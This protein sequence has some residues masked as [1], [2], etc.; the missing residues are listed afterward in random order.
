MGEILSTA[1]CPV[2][3]SI[4]TLGDDRDEDEVKT[5]DLEAALA[6]RL[7]LL[8]RGRNHFILRTSMHDLGQDRDQGYHTVDN[9]VQ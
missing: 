5:S 6:S 7:V 2:S 1:T 9:Q 3:S 4:T 8:L